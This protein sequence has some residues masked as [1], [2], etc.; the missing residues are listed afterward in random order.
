MVPQNIIALMKI[1][2]GNTYDG[3]ILLPLVDEK[4]ANGFNRKKLQEILTMGVLETGFRCSRE[5]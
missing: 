5:G 1:T 4:T 3:D 2:P